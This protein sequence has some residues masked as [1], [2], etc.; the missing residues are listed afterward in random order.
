MRL[1]HVLVVV[2][3]LASS[4]T[5]ATKS[6]PS[7]VISTN[8]FDVKGARSLRVAKSVYKEERM[9]PALTKWMKTTIWLET[10]KSDDYVKKTLGLDELSG[11]ALKSAPNYAYYEHF[12]Q[13]LEGRKLDLWLTKGVLSKD[14]WAKYRLDDVPTAQLKEN[15]GFKTYLRYA[16]MQDEN[17][18]KQRYYDKDVAIDYSGTPAEMEAKVGMWLSL[19]RPDWYVKKMLNLDRRSRNS[20]RG[21]ENYP[22]YKKFANAMEG[23]QLEKWLAA[24]IP[25]ERVWRISKLDDIP[26]AKLKNNEAYHTYVRY[27]TMVDDQNFQLKNSGKEVKVELGGSTAE[28]EAKVKIWASAKRPNKYVEEML[29]LDSAALATSPN[30]KYYETFVK[31]TGQVNKN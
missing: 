9:V 1:C 14:V 6:S 30:Y 17:I 23:R 3:L 24:G 4:G 29:N 5:L 31:L 22:L 12:L 16:T 13:A 21:S 25:T 27:A 26:Q 2:A 10:G 28:L 15:D 8:S 11:A 7:R 19:D 20:L 18:Y